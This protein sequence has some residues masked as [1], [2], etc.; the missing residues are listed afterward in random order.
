MGIC[1]GASQNYDPLKKYTTTRGLAGSAQHFAQARVCSQ[2]D[3]AD[4]SSGACSGLDNSKV[5]SLLLL[6]LLYLQEG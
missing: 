3:A 5:A 2:I 1:Q 6:H 4:Q